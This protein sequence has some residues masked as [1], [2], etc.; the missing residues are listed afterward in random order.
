MGINNLRV[1]EQVG[2]ILNQIDLLINEKTEARLRKEY[3]ESEDYDDS[4]SIG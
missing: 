4:L 2:G 1:R 3:E